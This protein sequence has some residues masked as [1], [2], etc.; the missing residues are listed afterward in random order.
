MKRLVYILAVLMLLAAVSCRK[1]ILYLQYPGV[2][3]ETIHELGLDEP[4][5]PVRIGFYLQ[6]DE[7]AGPGTRSSIVGGTE[8]PSEFI[9]DMYMVCFTKEGI[10]LGWRKA[11]LMGSEQLYTHTSG[12][13]CQGRELFEGT[14][15]SRTARIH[16]VSNVGIGVADGYAPPNIPGNDQVGGNENTLVKSARM[17]VGLSNTTICYWG[18]HGEASSEDMKAWLA[19]ADPQPDGSVIYGKK[20]GSN[21]HLIR[22]RARVDFGYMLDFPRTSEQVEDGQTITVNGV[23]YTIHGGKITINGRDFE[24]EKN[25]TDYTI[26]EIWWILSNGLDKG[27][28]APYHDEDPNDHFS[29]YFDPDATPPLLEDRLTPYDKA[30]AARYTAAESDMVQVY[31]GTNSISNSLFLFEDNNNPGDPPKIIVK[32]VYQVDGQSG[33]KTKYHTLMMLNEVQ[34]P[35]KIYRNHNYTLDIF[36]LPW[37]GLGYASFEDAVNS[38][39]YSN[40]QTV[41]ISENVPAVNDGRFQLSIT[42]DTNLIFQDP[43]LVGTQQTI[44]FKYTAMVSSEST[45]EIT[46]DSFSAKWTEE[47]RSSFASNTVSI[48]EVSNDGTTFTGHITFTLGTTI[49]ESLQNGQIELR[50]KHTGLSRFINVYTISQFNFLPSGSSALQLVKTGGTRMVNGASC[51]TYKLDVRIPGNYPLG[52]YPIKI[53]MATTTLNPFR[54]ER[55]STGNSTVELTEDEVSVYMEGTENGTVLDGETLYGMI[56]T[57]ADADKLE[58]NYHAAGEPWNFWCIYTI[59]N[60]PTVEQNGSTVEDEVDKIYTIYLDDI[61]PLRAEANRADDVGLFLKIKYFGP[62]VAISYQ[63]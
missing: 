10:Y 18:F 57:T 8:D 38:V 43:S 63:P 1:E 11:V 61:R 49:N 13:V 9:K 40:N 59:I 53:R 23:G 14:V 19:V 20:E 33:T 36:G 31:D 7:T 6:E 5:M 12:I 42:G 37:E 44:T 41:T 17:C 51:D 56:F 15:P 62:A 26:K 35:C 39:T 60:K 16:F 29:G 50:D 45:S 2:P 24:I 52:L 21:V 25:P 32:V 3:A 28:L 22:D 34:E 27:Y 4:E 54:A 58:W 46:I 55:R 48:S 30:D 47:V